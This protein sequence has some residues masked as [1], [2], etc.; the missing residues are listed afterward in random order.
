MGQFSSVRRQATVRERASERLRKNQTRKIRKNAINPP[1]S[2]KTTTTTTRRSREIFTNKYQRCG[3]GVDEV[4]ERVGDEYHC[5]QERDEGER[6]DR[7]EIRRDRRHASHAHTH[8]N[9]RRTNTAPKERESERDR[10]SAIICLDTHAC[11]QDTERPQ[12][13]ARPCVATISRSHSRN[14]TR[15]MSV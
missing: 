15:L 1:L 11:T 12:L 8:M 6:E 13:A 4:G 5:V 7:Q 3:D 2:M 10:I 9:D 14:H